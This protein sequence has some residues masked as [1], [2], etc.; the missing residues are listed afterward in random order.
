MWTLRNTQ[1]LLKYILSSRRRTCRAVHALSILS[2]DHQQDWDTLVPGVQFAYNSSAHASTGFPPFVLVTG[3]IP[4]FPE[5]GWLSTRQK[6]T[7]PQYL[8][9]LYATI[10]R[11]HQEA[12]IALEKSYADLKRRYDAKRRDVQLP[13]GTSVLIRLSDYERNKF[14]CRKLAPRWS[15]PAEVIACLSNHKTYRVRQHDGQEVTVNVAR[16][17]RT[18]KEI[19][20]RSQA[21][22]RGSWWSSLRMRRKSSL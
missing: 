13:V 5:E 2:R 4:T 7:T 18:S 22:R 14:D 6:S 9:D 12:G 11:V 3:R 10:A 16:I 15:E 17:L 19:L 1:N 20:K 8:R 21:L